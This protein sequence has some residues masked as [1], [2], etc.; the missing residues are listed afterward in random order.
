MLTDDTSFKEV[1]I[2]G[3]IKALS[4]KET[5]HDRLEK[6]YND[7]FINTEINILNTDNYQ[8][9]RID[10]TKA[11]FILPKTCTINENGV[12]FTKASIKRAPNSSVIDNTSNKRQK[13]K[14]EKN[15][16]S[17]LGNEVQSA[18]H[19]NIEQV[20]KGFLNYCYGLYGYKGSFL[21]NK[22]VADTVTT[23]ARNITAVASLVMECFGGDFRYY[24]ISAHNKIIEESNKDFKKVTRKYTLPKVTDDEVLRNLLGRHYE[25]YY[26]KSFLISKI[27]DLSEDEKS[28]LYLRNNFMAWVEV[29]EVKEVFVSIL[30]KCK[31]ERIN[32][33]DKDYLIGRF[34]IEDGKVQPIL[35]ENVDEFINKDLILATYALNPKNPLFKDDFNLLKS[36]AQDLMYGN[37]YFGSDYVEGTYQDT[38]V[39]IISAMHRDRIVTIDTDSTV[40]TVFKEARKLTYGIFSKYIDK[41]DEVMVYGVVPELIGICALGLISKVFAIYTELVGVEEE[42]RHFVELEM[43]HVMQHLQLTVSK[44][45]YSF[46]SLIK[47]YM[48][49]TKKKMEVRGLKYIKSDTNPESADATDDILKNFIMKLPQELD[50]NGLLKHVFNVTE[51]NIR[52]IESEDYVLNKNTKL[53]IKE[54]SRYGDYRSKAVR[55]WNMMADEESKIRIPGAFGCIRIKITKEILEVIKLKH[56]KVYEVMKKFCED[57]YRFKVTSKIIELAELWEDGLDN[58]KLD[59]KI[60]KHLPEEMDDDLSTAFNNFMHYATKYD[61]TVYNEE[62]WYKYTKD[63]KDSKIEAFKAIL[64][65]LFGRSVKEIDD[66]IIKEVN[67]IAIPV[68]LVECPAWIGINNFEMVDVESALEVEHLISSMIYGIG[69][70]ITKNKSKNY[71]VTNILNVF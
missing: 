7:N 3:V 51:E 56:T 2:D 38:T 24:T 61:K 60:N 4:L 20:V 18:T 6:I 16:N 59:K 67:R 32:T 30:S 49:S 36:M 69:V 63:V 31:K 65:R 40:S 19:A 17:A 11:F 54:D 8:N 52:N 5:E 27:K 35:K 21:F 22:E 62:L 68:D 26:A 28:V 1:W 46:I 47:D 57:L 37:F 39:D 9:K 25:G 64:E 50:Y 48:W 14:R 43:E 29:P 34:S 66:E 12:L 55:L 13:E 41:E 45:Q 33:D 23:G 70:C 10:T 15:V 71:T 44:K 42:D 53:K 58:E